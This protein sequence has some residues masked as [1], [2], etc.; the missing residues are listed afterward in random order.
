M[1]KVTLVP[2]KCPQCGAD[3]DVDKNLETAFCS[4]CGTK[5]IIKDVVKKVKIVNNPTVENFIKLGNRYY[6]EESYGEALDNYKQA[7][8]IDPDNW[9]V[10]YKKG[11]CTTRTTTLGTFD[12]EASVNGCKNALKLLVDSEKDA[13][14][15]AEVKVMMAV[16]LKGIS[17]SFYNFAMNHYN[18]FWSLEKSATEMWSRLLSVR[19]C[20]KY[21]KDEL[22]TDDVI[23]KCPKTKSDV[24]TKELRKN[25]ALDLITFA[26][27]I[28]EVRKYKSGYTQYGDI[29]SNTKIRDDIRSELV[30]DYDECVAL[31]K[32]TQPEYVPSEINRTG[33]AKGCYVATAVYGS[34][35]CP[36]VW[37]LRRYRDF[38]LD[39]NIFGKLF[40]KAYYFISPKVIKVFGNNKWFNTINKNILNKFVKKLQDKGFEDTKYNDKY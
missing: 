28:C 25:F 27:V 4:Y 10:V 14:K 9:E 29:Y 8:E 31:V 34:Y 11:I 26:V 1:K 35:D 13:K 15:I 39:E 18:E 5:I 30:K 38:V 6:E 36:E 16:E 22:L 12:V 3:I 40:I 19:A 2:A 37:T 17:V 20:A 32:E 7:L 24:D 33:E 21:A 23:E